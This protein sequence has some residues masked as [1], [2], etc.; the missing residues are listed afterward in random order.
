[1]D[2]TLVSILVFTVLKYALFAIILVLSVWLII[3]VYEDL[4]IDEHSLKESVKKNYKLWIVTL[5]SVVF[6]F[7]I[8]VNESQWRPKNELNANHSAVE[9][10]QEEIRTREL[11]EV[12]PPTPSVV[13]EYEDNLERNREE[14][15]RAREEFLKLPLEN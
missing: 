9:R 10:V 12:K 2:P 5:L 4:S 14:N 6:L 15:Q 11:P 13:D 1:M 7:M 3:R 8:L